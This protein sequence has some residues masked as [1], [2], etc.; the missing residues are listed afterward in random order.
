MCH[1]KMLSNLFCQWVESRSSRTHLSGQWSKL[2]RIWDD[3]SECKLLVLHFSLRLMLVAS[4][5][6]GVALPNM[7]KWTRFQT[8]WLSL[9]MNW[10]VHSWSNGGQ[11][12][13]AC[14]TAFS[15]FI[16][17]RF[18]LAKP[19]SACPGGER[20]H[21]CHLPPAWMTCS[22]KCTLH[23]RDLKQLFVRLL[24]ARNTQFELLEF[25]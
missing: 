4:A 3:P 24:I 11:M 13:K 19:N 9:S 6:L 10:F 18:A 8:P 17:T 25:S 12:A 20:K 22:L 7:A 16:F 23:I 2:H 21:G 5:L 15:T 1:Q 14:K